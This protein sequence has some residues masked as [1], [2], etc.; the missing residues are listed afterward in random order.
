M[1]NVKKTLQAYD[2]TL[3]EFANSLRISRPT[4]NNYISIF[5]EGGEIPKK[6]IK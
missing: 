5:E 3:S 6:N 4:L 1:Q 2:I